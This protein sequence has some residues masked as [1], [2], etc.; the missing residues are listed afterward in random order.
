MKT[1][2]KKEFVNHLMLI[3][4]LLLLGWVFG[5]KRIRP[6]GNQTLILL[7]ILYCFRM[8]DY[9]RRFFH[10]STIWLYFFDFGL[11]PNLAGLF[12]MNP[13]HSHHFRLTLGSYGPFDFFDICIGIGIAGLLIFGLLLIGK[14]YPYCKE[15]E[16]GM[17]FWEKLQWE[18][19]QIG[20]PSLK[21]PFLP[22]SHWKFDDSFTESKLKFPARSAITGL[23]FLFLCSMLFFHKLEDYDQNKK[24]F[25][26]TASKD[27]EETKKE[28]NETAQEELSEKAEKSNLKQLPEKKHRMLHYPLLSELPMQVRR[29]NYIGLTSA[30]LNYYQ[31]KDGDTLWGIA[32]NFYQNGAE[33][34]VLLPLNPE[35]PED[36][37]LIYPDMELQVPDEIYY[38][39]KQKL[40]R[41][42]FRSPSCFYDAPYQWTYRSVN[43]EICL[44]DW[45]SN[46]QDEV[47]VYTHITKNR[48]FSKGLNSEE[49]EQMQHQIQDAMKKETKAEF[50]ELTFS[51]YLTEDGKNL[52]LYTFLCGEKGN[53]TQYAVAYVMGKYY[54]AEFIGTA[55]ALAESQ[56][57]S[58]NSEIGEITRYMAASFVEVDEEKS[59]SHLKYRPYLG[60]ENWPF[61]DLHNP[62]AMAAYLYIPA[63]ENPISFDGE[64]QNLEF[65]SKR[66]ESLLYN[67][68]AHYYHFDDNEKRELRKRPL[69]K[70]DLAFI[71]EIELLESAIPGRDIV[72]FHSG[73]KS[74]S[75][76]NA[77]LANY[78]I[79]TLEDIAKL[80]NLQKL[81]LEIGNVSDYEVLGNC[82][83]LNY[84]AI[85]SEEFLTDLSWL[86]NLPNLKTLSLNVSDIALLK[87]FGYQRE[88]GSTFQNKIMV[89]KPVKAGAIEEALSACTSLEYLE[90]TYSEPLDFHF[91]ENLP[92]LYCFRLFEVENYGVEEEVQ[93]DRTKYF[94][95]EFCPWIK[96]LTVDD[97][98]LR[99]PE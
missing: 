27:E 6:T 69:R 20:L 93:E 84:L 21:A 79:S 32:R 16:K 86:Q 5:C 36:G 31:V 53:Q 59:F 97:R 3:F 85:S 37:S 52:I 62:F 76:E 22:T 64:D 12:K 26:Q 95:E 34:K 96:C 46:Y 8:I 23:L 83:S 11:V 28:N 92:N 25:A 82:K 9:F 87:K 30:N 63:E 71:T 44:D 35:L 38:I 15:H 50:S 4:L 70:S 18:W 19:K 56:K 47:K 77:V 24:D 58:F 54:L 60:H 61:E 42:G 81:M 68:V 98:W 48:E 66:W 10:I 91:L 89:K 65:V 41:G 55:P 57:D 51:R 99:N 14:Y 29:E 49:W 80:P 74:F 2:Q 90:L 40:S 88:E 78:E 94:P 67:M 72:E 13:G 17:K 73:Q 43:W 1:M 33:W 39:P 45:V 7:L 75:V